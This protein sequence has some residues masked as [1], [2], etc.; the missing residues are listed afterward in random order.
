MVAAPRIV[1]G[2]ARYDFDVPASPVARRR[3]ATAWMPDLPAAEELRGLA[4]VA[5]DAAR[6]FGAEFADVRIGVQRACDGTTSRLEFGYGIRARTGTAWAFEHGNVMSRDAMVRSARAA[7]AGA[8][9]A[10]RVN[11][12]LGW[13]AP[14]GFAHVPA[15]TGTWDCPVD[16]DPFSVPLNEFDAFVARAEAAVRTTAPFFWWA[17][18]QASWTEETRVVA[19]TEGTLITQTFTRGGPNFHVESSLWGQQG[20]EIPITPEGGQSG[21]FELVLRPEWERIVFERLEPLAVLRELPSK[22]F[23]DVGRFPVVLDGEAFASLVSHTLNFALDG[24][25]VM[26]TES[27]ASGAGFVRPFEM[28]T[29]TAAYD[30]APALTIMSD[31]A[32]PS[33]VAAQWDDEGVA[34]SSTTLIDRG[35]V[36]DFH[37]TRESAPWLSPWYQR[38]QRTPRL[39]GRTTAPTAASLPMANGGQL[40]VT[41]ATSRTSI[42]DLSRDM[43]HGFWVVGAKVNPSSNLSTGM[44]RPRFAVEIRRGVPVALIHDMW[45]SFSTLAILKS[46]LVMLGDASTLHTQMGEM[47]KGIP[48]QTMRNPTTAPAALCKQIDVIQLPKA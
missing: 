48:W 45:M 37:V 39:A 28:P 4:L 25:R 33:S 11:A 2:M 36:T 22:S 41:P 10:G 19:S 24:D 32:T 7:A 26:G 18:A 46:G 20:I 21:G 47:E 30:L 34:T 38:R 31:R 14:E 17:Q 5:V 23:N 6:T 40:G 29:N 3:P 27:D 44:L 16:I 1:R 9:V 43:T 42:A 12:T 35:R 15:A 13:T 8:T